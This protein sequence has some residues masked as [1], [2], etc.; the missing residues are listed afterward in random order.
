[1]SPV[2]ADHDEHGEMVRL[3]GLIATYHPPGGDQAVFTRYDATPAFLLSADEAPD[4]R[5]PSHG[6]T[7]QW[8]GVLEILRPGTY[9]F[10][11]RRTG[12]FELRID[13]RPVALPDGMSGDGHLPAMSDPV[14]LTF[15]LHE[16]EMRYAATVVDGPDSAGQQL[17][18]YWQ[19]DSFPREPLPSFAVGH[20]GV[21][22]E[23]D[24]GDRSLA[25]SLSPHEA[26]PFPIGRLTVEEHS[27]VACHRPTDAVPLSGQLWTRPGP[28]LSR[29]GG[30]LRK[31]WMYHWLGDPQA[32][33]PDAIM[34]R[35]F[36]ADRA[37][38]IERHA[39][40]AYLESLGGPLRLE[41]T[42]LVGPA[43]PL[44]TLGEELFTRTG[45]VVCHAGHD[46]QRPRATLA[47]LG[48]KT[49][50]EA[51]GMFLR[52]T[53]AVDPSGRMPDFALEKADA[54]GIALYLVRR[55]AEALPLL[56]LPTTPSRE[57]LR[58][59]LLATNASDADAAD[60]D[61]QPLD[62]H[63]RVLGR[64]LMRTK[65]CT[66]CH[67]MQPAGETDKEYWQP[68]PARADFRAIAA[69]PDRGCL[70]PSDRRD[71]RDDDEAPTFGPSLD[72]TAASGFLTAATTAPGTQAPGE[73]ARLTIERFNC[74]GCHQR[75]GAGGLGPELQSRM[76]LGQTAESAELI[77]PPPLTG[78]SE[79]L[80]G[81]YL[82]R[83]LEDDFRA[84]PW[85]GLK[86]PRFGKQHMRHLP[87]GLAALD[88]E[89][90]RDEAYTPTAEHDGNLT[91]F[92]QAGRVL[93]G[94][95]G[96]GCTKCHDMLGVASR[97]TRGPELSQT[98][99]RVNF[100]WYLRWM[101]DPQRIQPGTR[102]PTVFL[103]GQSPHQD[104]LGGDPDRQRMAIWQYLLSAKDLPPPE[105]LEEPKLAGPDRGDR[106][107]VFRTFLP[108]TTARAMAIR[109]P[110]DVHLAYDAQACRLAYGWTG[111]FL[112]TEPVW[113]GRGGNRA[114]IKGPIFWTAPEGFPWEV[115][116]SA[117]PAPDFTGRAAD[118]ALGAPL[119]D[120]GQL[121]PRRLHFRGYA[122]GGEGPSFRYELDLPGDRRAKFVETVSPLKADAAV[123][124]LRVVKVT[125]P[126]G[127]FAWL[128]VADADAP[129]SWQTAAGD[130]GT[131]DVA[132]PIAPADAVLQLTQQ[133]RPL[134]LRLRQASSGA[135]WLTTEQAGKWT[136]LVRV[137]CPADGAPATLAV[138][139]WTPVEGQDAAI[140][141]IV[142]G[143]LP[144]NPP[145]GK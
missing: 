70:L 87:V 4:P 138:A 145:G 61:Q 43:E 106:P 28:K 79:R 141:G 14:E 67:E 107:L 123:G 116:H 49:T 75:D 125:A 93:V 99:A 120:D 71:A 52:K 51:L 131:L 136:V 119:P 57:E 2:V 69:R 109:F 94:A 108:G 46:G 7:V 16:I 85:M 17:K 48:R 68:A 102:M 121:H 82:R 5:L 74:T 30:R 1:M 88:G 98:A 143:E 96:F 12:A 144:S 35:M 128:K 101:T 73:F 26:D 95:K 63:L 56:E 89:P 130:S 117:S 97:G 64:R 50:P 113:G 54:E 55:D 33:R 132:R 59:L 9:R 10:A 29:A 53:A 6:W 133:G 15:G 91:E 37:G 60:F 44:E 72:R 3:P 114:G 77:T 126:V 22:S 111:D 104:V 76:L 39:V 140:E 20:A 139:L 81:G 78:A 40:T 62:R 11:A 36:T 65:R 58:P 90:L 105:G 24:E 115:T 19:S 110:N 25:I 38:E 134:V 112:D 118:T 137:P 32:L 41:N 129:P 21:V 45:C 100:D 103:G 42:P 27:C 92:A 142:R 127:D 122:T 31:A 80:L 47:G 66:A 84:R 18:L 135:G 124:A 23:D 13:D 34:P 83:V 86:M 8:R